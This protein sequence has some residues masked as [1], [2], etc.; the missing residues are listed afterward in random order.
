MHGNHICGLETLGKKQDTYG[1]ILIPIVLAKILTSI[2]HNIIRANGTNNWTV[3]Q[4]RKTILREIQISEAGEE[5][6]IFDHMNKP[7]NT[8]PCTSSFLTNTSPI[9]GRDF[10]N[11]NIGNPTKP[12]LC[13]FCCGPHGADKCTVVRDPE[14]RKKIA[15]QSNLCFNCLSNRR[16]CQCNSKNRCRNSYKKHDISLCNEKNNEQ[17]KRP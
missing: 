1:D 10:S 7:V 16:V 5:T 4:L 13:V 9:K 8:F 2:K 11:A 3:V 17:A 6:E 14:A 15:F 12:K